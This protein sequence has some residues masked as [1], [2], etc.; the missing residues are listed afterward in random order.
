MNYDQLY[1]ALATVKAENAKL[2]RDCSEANRRFDEAMKTIHLQGQ[3]IKSINA[4]G[5][6][7]LTFLADSSP[8]ESPQLRTRYEPATIGACLP[9]RKMA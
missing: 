3:I 1:E 5:D 8:A 7:D 2:K 6:D 9:P 4:D